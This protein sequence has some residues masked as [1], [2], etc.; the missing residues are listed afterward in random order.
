MTW[1]HGRRAAHRCWRGVP[2]LAGGCG[3]S[4]RS[5][6][7]TRRPRAGYLPETHPLSILAG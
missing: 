7:W 1:P 4:A 5:A 2:A 3:H 6:R